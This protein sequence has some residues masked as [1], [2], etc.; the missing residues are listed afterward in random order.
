[1]LEQ[2]KREILCLE[3]RIG[4]KKLWWN[5]GV[6]AGPIEGKAQQDD[7]WAEIPKNT[8]KGE[9]KQR[10]IRRTFKILREVWLNIKVEKV[11]TYEGVIVKALLDSSATGMFMDKKMAAKHGF[12]LQKLDRPVMVRNVDGTNNSGRAIIHQVEVNVYYKSYV[13]RMRIDVCNLGR[14]DIILGMLWLQAHNPEINWETGEVKI[15]RCPP[16]CGRKIVVKE[17][18]ERKRKLEKRIRTI[19]KPDRDEWK[20]SMEEKFDDEVELDKEKVRKMV[21]PRFYKWLKVLEKVESKMI[22]VRK[23]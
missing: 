20:M 1:M 6:V 2:E 4:R 8:A 16:I 22:P 13:D 3:Y 5:W 7:I 21:P 18:I 12:K 17:G 15:T 10:D 23:P 11:D 14:T 19:E 9:D